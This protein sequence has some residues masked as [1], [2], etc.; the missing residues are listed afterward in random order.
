V[1][2][3]RLVDLLSDLIARP[4][5]NPIY[6]P[7]SPGEAAVAGYVEAWAD[8]LG[9]PVR[10]QEVFPGR[11]NLVIRLDGPAGAPTLLMEAHMDTVGVSEMP[12]AFTP[13]LRDGC[14]YGRGACDT[15][16][17]LAAMMAAVE[18]LS[19]ERDR[20]ACSVELLAAVDEE[21]SGQGARAHVRAGNTADAAIVG[22]PTA[23]RI[24]NRHNGVVRG[25]IEVTG[26]AAH[27]SVASEGINA[28][29]AMAE[30]IL[31][32]R[33][34]NAA[35]TNAPGGQ[36]ATGSLTVSLIE[37]GSGIN[38]VPETCV[39]QYD[40]RVVPGLTATHALAEIDAALETVRQARPEVRIA[41]HEPWLVGDALSTAPD[42][43]IVQAAMAAGQALGLDPEPAFVPYGSDASK[44]AAGGI[45]AVVFGPGSI[46]YAHSATEHVPVSDLV[47]AA[48]FYRELALS[49]GA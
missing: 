5:V 44:F 25:K 1:N 12:D 26:K 40:R 21:T 6:D 28:I 18:A 43:T 22:E 23:L 3:S 24:V 32:L 33:A 10:R 13:T 27:T 29:D 9:L 2:E 46:A 47:R 38:V 48:A 17:S 7:E 31:A 15:K 19:G 37:G 34:V 45:P 41:R 4:S 8:E 11:E 30:V 39:I 42:T 35:L 49:F 14:L 16:G 36:P 20:L